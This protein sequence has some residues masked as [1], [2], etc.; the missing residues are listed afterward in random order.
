MLTENSKNQFFKVVDSLKKYRRADIKDEQG[1]SI[2]NNLYVDAMPNEQ[3]LK[4]CL[5]NNTTFLIGRKGTGKSTILL[6]LE[7]EYTAKKYYIPC[8]IDVKT[9]F[10]ASQSDNSVFD[11]LNG[12]LPTEVLSKYLIQRLF[13]Q[14][15]LTE[16][17]T[18]IDKKYSSVFEKIKLAI[19]LTK[20]KQ[21]KEDLKALLESIKC[22][23][24]LQ[25]IEIPSITEAS[26]K[27]KGV[28]SENIKDEIKFGIKIPVNCQGEASYG[29]SNSKEN[30]LTKEWEDEFSR[31]FI[32]LFQIKNIITQTKEIL[33]L[34]EIRHLI[35]MLDDFSEIDELGIK[36]FVDTILAPLNNWSDEFI[37]FKVAAYP[38][39][40]HYGDIDK[41]KIDIIELD[42]YNLYS[43]DRSS[44]EE[45]AVD[46]TKRLVLNRIGYFC[47]EPESVFFDTKSVD[48]DEY[49]E[50]LFHTSMNIPRILGYILFYSY[51]TNIV[52]D[53]P[54]NKKAIENAAQTYYEKNIYSFFEKSTYSLMTYDNKVS[55]LQQ[56]E[57]IEIYVDKMKEIKKRI[58]TGELSSEI[59]NKSQP[60]TSHFNIFPVFEQFLSTLELNFFLTKYAEM[61]DRDGKTVSIYALNYGLA[62]K[63][64]LRWGKQ[65]GNAFRKYFISRPF[66]FSKETE[67]FLRN[68]KKI[69]CTNPSCNKLYPYEELKYLKYAKMRCV[70]CQ[71]TVEVLSVSENIEN[72]LNQIDKSKLLPSIEFSLLYELN[73]HTDAI[74]AKDIAEELDVSSKLIGRR[75]KKLDEEKQLIERIKT[76]PMTYKITEKCKKI[77]FS[78]D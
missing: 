66:D 46:Y 54:I 62:T 11:Y 26:S 1:R 38:G 3:V 65:R 64:N 19:G 22:N 27:I 39:R 52:F 30:I 50:L 44:M 45:R 28:S 31:I 29:T 61:S 4:N 18:A 63:H 16:L 68:A 75:A 56:K 15:I 67:D 41:G 49:Y 36:I 21:V 60:Y 70:E 71:S 34:L 33:S 5:T 48:M 76:T 37:K 2:I 57:L 51:Q 47:D 43:S 12:R 35:V 20:A 78:K 77:Y 9:I 25:K 23:E 53:S 24:L 74:Y 72:K 59:Y 69:V 13:I 10:E 58:G 6:R 55:I 8:Y 32:K 17:L 14:N 7:Q 73:K 42:F 40:V